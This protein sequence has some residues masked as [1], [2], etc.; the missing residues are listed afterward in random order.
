MKQNQTGI[1]YLKSTLTKIND[2]VENIGN[3]TDEI[4]ERISKLEDRAFENTHWKR[5]KNWGIKTIA[6]MLGQHKNS[7]YWG[8]RVT[9]EY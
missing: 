2:V 9:W 6:E 1:F 3:R 7:K 5:K 4:E 8:L